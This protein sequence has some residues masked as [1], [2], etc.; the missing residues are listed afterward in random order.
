MPDIDLYVI[1]KLDRRQPPEA[2]AAQLTA[3]LNRTDPRDS[4]TRSRIETA[5]VILGDPA[6]R[7]Q[8]D[9]QL[10]DPSAPAITE[11]TL[12]QLSGRTAPTAPRRSVT[13]RPLAIVAAA[14][15]VLLVIGIV[16]VVTLTGGDDDKDTTTAQN[17]GTSQPTE[18]SGS[19]GSAGSQRSPAAVGQTVKHD[20]VEWA[21]IKA[22][23][24]TNRGQICGGLGINSR[25]IGVT[26]EGKN[27]GASAEQVFSYST[28]NVIFSGRA[29]SANCAE[30]GGQ[31]KTGTTSIPAG[32]SQQITYFFSLPDTGSD[33][34]TFIFETWDETRIYFTLSYS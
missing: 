14:T 29:R 28:Q 26:V 17:P 4:L 8:Y 12:A 27:T 20:G 24:I 33:P 25:V 9:Q 5:R 3:E 6:R 32:Q 34:T 15:V 19:G 21:V 23:R 30:V 2:L 13:A 10:N 31:V 16:L 22:E 11:A 18:S 7:T 1:H